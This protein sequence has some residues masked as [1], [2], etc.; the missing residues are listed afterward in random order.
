MNRLDEE[1]EAALVKVPEPVNRFPDFVRSIVNKLRLVC[2]FLGKKRLA[3]ILARSGIHLA[4]TTV[5]RMVAER[6]GSPKPPTAVADVKATSQTSTKR[7]I[8]A[9]HTHH[10]WQLDLTVIPTRAG[11]WTPWLPFALGQSWPACWWLALVIDHFSRHVVGYAVFEKQPASIEVRAFLGRAFTAV[12]R[13][14]R[15]LVTDLG[16][17]FTASDFRSWCDKKDVHLR[18]ASKASI[19]ATAVV[20]RFFLSLKTEMLHRISVSLR[21]DAFRRQLESYFAWYHERRP[22]QGLGGKTPDEVY[23]GLA[24][25]QTRPRFE[26]R[27]RWPRSAPC[28]KP[29]APMRAGPGWPLQLVV[30]F[31]DGDRRLPVVEIK[32][33]A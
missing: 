31:V 28:A 9:R 1:G 25:A 11:F 2:P 18:Y 4:A 21:R 13:A 30:D 20:E 3:Q 17:Q 16:A 10:V 24:P 5:R 7:P 29:K 32:R 6:I 27:A 15:Y 14:P 19:R 12:G 26:P 22:H 23:L 33:A 8:V